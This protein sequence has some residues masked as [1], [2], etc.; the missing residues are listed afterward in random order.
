MQNNKYK[1]A[2]NLKQH[3]RDIFIAPAN[4][5]GPLDGIRAFSILYVMLM[6]S[7]VVLALANPYSMH[8]VLEHTRWYSQWILM[9]DKGV[10]SF[11]VLSGF[12]IA[13]LLFREYQKHQ[14]IKLKRFFYRRWLRLTPVYFL[15]LALFYFF[16]TNNVE[17]QYLWAYVF[18]LNNF[19]DE[20]HRYLP[21]LWSLAVE[22]QFYIVF[23]VFTA[24]ILF[25]VKKP[26]QLLLFL[27]VAS[28]VIR[29]AI[30]AFE[31]QLL[32]TG[33]SLLYGNP[34]LTEAYNQALY[35]NLHSRFGPIITGV[36]LAYCYCFHQGAL[37]AFSQRHSQRLLLVA[38][39]LLLISV[40][41]PVYGQQA[42]H[43]AVLYVYHI[44]HRHIFALAI[45]LFMVLG[46]YPQQGLANKINQFLAWRGFFPIAQLSY[47]LYLFHLMFF[48]LVAKTFFASDVFSYSQA[49]LLLLCAML[50]CLLFSA[51]TFVFV[52]R[53]MMHLR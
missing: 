20:A 40:L 17:A 35:I 27:Y 2:L 7:A 3:W 29:A 6:H 24:F 9:G 14:G 48:M 10:D 18:Y 49:W 21:H 11:F 19:L 51:L 37:Q 13:H 33:H 25:K 34:S 16:K 50:P 52:E 46:L 4:R 28:L 22:E 43:R 47:S 41:L 12:L 38:V 45:V 15:L 31:P 36:I 53:P 5:Y 1:N 8:T 30:I 23:S 26:W 39:L 42:P 32:T 44:A